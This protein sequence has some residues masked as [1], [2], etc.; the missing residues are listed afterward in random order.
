M[1]ACLNVALLIKLCMSY[2]VT[3]ITIE[4]EMIVIAPDRQGTKDDGCQLVMH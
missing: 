1:A 2:H 3:A 4:S